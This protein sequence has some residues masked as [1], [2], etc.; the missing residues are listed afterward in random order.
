VS[1]TE[2][3]VHSF[4]LANSPAQAA[5]W[6]SNRPNRLLFMGGG[7]KGDLTMSFHAWVRPLALGIAVAAA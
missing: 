6:S 2:S 3:F 4:S 5:A 1:S 7:T